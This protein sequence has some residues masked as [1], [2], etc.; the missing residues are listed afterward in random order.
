MPQCYLSISLKS[1][2]PVVVIFYMLE[3][4][5]CSLS[6]EYFHLAV[7]GYSNLSRQDWLMHKIR[8]TNRN[9]IPFSRTLV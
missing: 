1:N 4:E 3:G 5:M 7:N 6:E 9:I 2:H 8:D